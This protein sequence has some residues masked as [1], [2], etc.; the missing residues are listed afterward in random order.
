MAFNCFE[1]VEKELNF[2]K[3]T[4]GDGSS[5]QEFENSLF[6]TLAVRRKLRPTPLH[7]GEAELF[8]LLV[9]VASCPHSPASAPPPRCVFLAVEGLL[10]YRQ[11]SGAPMSSLD[12]FP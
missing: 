8:P 12:A 3:P 7:F 10:L 1:G 6:P 9:S 11:F 4:V 2:K 5:S